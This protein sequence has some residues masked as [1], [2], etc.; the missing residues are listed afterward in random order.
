MPND[1]FEVK[2]I[3]PTMTGDNVPKSWF[4][5]DNFEDD[6]RVRLDEKVS[7]DN[8]RGYH[9]DDNSMVRFTVSA[10]SNDTDIGCDNDF[11]ES[12]TRGYVYKKNDWMGRANS[13]VEFTGFF[14]AS[15]SG[16]TDNP[17]IMKGPTGEHHSNTKCCSGSSH[18]LHTGGEAE[19]INDRIAMRFSKEMWHVDYHTRSD[20]KII[21]NE[22]WSIN[23]NKW[24]GIKYIIY[25]KTI[26]N[27]KDVMVE[28]YLNPN[29][30][31]QSWKKIMTTT[32]KWGSNGDDCGG[33]K[34]DP[35]AFGNSRMMIRWD[36][37]DGS[38]IRFRDVSIRA[39]DPN[40]NFEPDP[41]N[42]PTN[43]PTTTTF[44]SI[45]RLQ[46]NINSALSL[47]DFGGL[48]VF[49]D[50]SDSATYIVRTI[51]DSDF[52]DHRTIIGERA[53]PAGGSGMKT[54]I[55]KEAWFL[56][57]KVGTP[58]GTCRAKIWDTNGIEK[59]SS[60]NTITCTTLGT[61]FGSYSVFDMSTNTYTMQ[62]GDRIG[63]QYTG[64]SEVD[65]IEIKARDPGDGSTGSYYGHFTDGA[66]GDIT[67][68]DTV[69]QLW[70]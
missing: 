10:D 55:V 34:D 22:T 57:R 53:N 16:P 38:D 14:K 8:S 37:R 44:R 40:A 9:L 68:R 39:I 69:M 58:A 2:M 6:P 29:A 23:D 45:L 32:G 35:L 12:T 64:N 65:Y 47:C 3:Y 51:G 49:F 28:A 20:Y 4:I 62:N 41:V 43:E 36:Y 1:K 63:V 27:V 48:S 54:N 15:D 13:G 11:A 33:S 52:T 56:L 7:G 30:D 60:V 67:S 42:P 26:N 25:K 59:Y 17:V 70:G 19:D 31:K 66:W 24:Y 21:P 61:S 18:M 46:R 5:H 50:I